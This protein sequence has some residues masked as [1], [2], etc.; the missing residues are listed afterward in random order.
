[1]GDDFG[2]V[3]A[4]VPFDWGGA[5]RLIGEFRSA[6]AAI[7]DKRGSR[8]SGGEHALVDWKGPHA[9]EFRHRLSTGDADAGEVVAALRR[10]ATQV[11]QLRAAAEAEQR[12]RV[13]AREYMQA[14]A[15]NEPSE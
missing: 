15:E 11:E 5:D 14:K 2:A 13:Q 3:E 9:D 6:A 12:R 10:S 1:M 7:E 8:R 4:D